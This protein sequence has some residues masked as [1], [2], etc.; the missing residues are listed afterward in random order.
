MSNAQGST[1][2]SSSTSQM[3]ASLSVMAGPDRG[4]VFALT[5]EFVHIGTA[6]DCQVV[7]T[8]PH[9]DE[10]QASLAN[11]ND[12][13]AI[14]TSHAKTVSVDGKVLPPEQWAWLPSQAMI[15]VSPE[16]TL[17]FSCGLPATSSVGE[18]IPQKVTNTPPQVDAPAALPTKTKG[19]KPGSKKGEGTNRT[20]AKF[21]TDRTGETLVRLGEDGHLPELSL[22][23][24]AAPKVDAKRQQKSQGNPAL[25][26]GAL[27]FSVLMSMA[28]LF[29]DASVSSE[30]TE[31]KSAARREVMR[32]FVG[33]D[34]SPIKP[35]QQ[36]LRDAGLAHSRG[37][38]K[39]EQAAYRKVLRLLNSE[40]K[41]PH[42]GIT[43]FV[44]DDERLK[45]HLAVL[46][47]R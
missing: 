43:G 32:D 27:G 17:L 3:I 25:I 4:K 41:N 9:A 21:I 29:M 28:M 26:Y 10:V 19:R 20:V 47:G 46:L 14:I 13:Y 34:K 6:D 22:N 35:Y 31:T 5:E 24:N 33:D 1:T 7:L 8:D 39:S 15:Q 42:T 23:E 11:R 40:D 38:V 2:A 45:K 16:T 36:L 12:R 37:D 44:E 18:L 30:A